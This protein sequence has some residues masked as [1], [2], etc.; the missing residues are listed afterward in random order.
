M[1]PAQSVN[2]KPPHNVPKEFSILQ[3][4][5][6]D[7]KLNTV[8]VCDNTSENDSC[9]A[10]CFTKPISSDKWSVICK[11]A[12]DLKD[13]LKINSPVL[14]NG[15]RILGFDPKVNSPIFQVA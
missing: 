5:V 10:V 4:V 2:D 7:Q 8:N 6:S 11:Q 13:H 12:V 15:L 14:V 9:L 1:D 3:S